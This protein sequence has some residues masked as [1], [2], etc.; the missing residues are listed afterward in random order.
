MNISQNETAYELTENE[1]ESV[2][3]G[4]FTIDMGWCALA[5]KL[6]RG[7]LTVAVAVGS[8]SGSVS[9]KLP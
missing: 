6:D 2:S 5:V 1:L 7:F 8:N 9:V 3:G 4:T